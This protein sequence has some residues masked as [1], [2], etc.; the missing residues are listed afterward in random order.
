[1]ENRLEIARLFSGGRFDQV[2]DSLS[3]AVEFHI[4]ED[5]KHLIGKAEVLGFCK[6]IAE[7]FASIETDFKE[8]GTVVCNDKVVIYGYG[9]FKRN[10]E[11]VNAVHSCDVY[12]FNSDGMIFQI[13]AY[14]NSRQFEDD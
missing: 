5:H 14:C 13:H 6:G 2:A 4:Y 9:E 8:S 1:M 11:L 3:D 10:G 7:Y 12:E